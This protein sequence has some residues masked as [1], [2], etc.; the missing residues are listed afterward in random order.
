MP[1]KLSAVKS[2]RLPLWVVTHALP[3]T[4]G[5]IWASVRADSKREAPELLG[6]SAALCCRCLQLRLAKTPVGLMEMS[7]LQSRGPPHRAALYFHLFF[8]QAFIEYL[9][10]GRSSAGYR[11]ELQSWRLPLSSH[12]LTVWCKNAHQWSVTLFFPLPTH[13]SQVATEQQPPP[14][15]FL[16]CGILG[17]WDLER[18]RERLEQ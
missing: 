17:G 11:A 8:H 5:G 1:T 3:W 6:Q 16:V 13:A 18:M 9:P 4:P 12:S 15:F 7:V 14:V 2:P 10:C